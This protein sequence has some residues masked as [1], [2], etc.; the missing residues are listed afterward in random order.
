MTPPRS[1]SE[2]ISWDRRF[3]LKVY[4]RGDCWEWRGAKYRNGYGHVTLGFGSTGPAHRLAYELAKG[5]I[6]PVLE[7]DHLCRHRWCVRPSHLEAVTTSI[8]GRRGEGFCG[9][10]ARKTQCKHGHPFNDANTYRRI[11]RGTRICRACDTLRHRAT[12]YFASSQ[13]A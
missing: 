1:W 5:P 13:D 11:D 8:N 7:I 4:P 9:H 12:R 6:G 10:A 2:S 3:W